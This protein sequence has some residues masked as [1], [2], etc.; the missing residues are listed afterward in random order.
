M[1][2]HITTIIALALL[3]QDYG[4]GVGT[5]QRNPQRNT[6][7]SLQIARI[8]NDEIWMAIA[9]A[10][11]LPGILRRVSS[12]GTAQDY[13]LAVFPNHVS[14]TPRWRIK[15]EYFYAVAQLP[16]HNDFGNILVRIPLNKLTDYQSVE[17][18]ER[19]K[20]FIPLPPIDFLSLTPLDPVVIAPDSPAALQKTMMKRADVIRHDFFIDENENIFLAIIAEGNLE[21]WKIESRNRWT[22]FAADEREDMSREWK[23]VAVTPI[24][25]SD[26]F[27]LEI[28]DETLSLITETGEL[29]QSDDRKTVNKW[30]EAD[31]VALDGNSLIVVDTDQSQIWLRRD[32]TGKIAGDT[33]PH[34]IKGTGKAPSD[35]VLRA[36]EKLSGAK[37]SLKK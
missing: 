15:G 22:S 13:T 14:P 24:T 35:R 12:E 19:S 4:I 34:L 16:G 2:L 7:N 31:N 36:F 20:G 37:P 18:L 21:L 9:P 3:L 26:R 23:R 5:L 11:G 17:E 29:W 32:S 1:N 10:N 25:L 30:R 6:D 27:I 28:N 8:V 33:Q